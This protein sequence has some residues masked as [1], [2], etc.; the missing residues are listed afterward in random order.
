MKRF[1]ELIFILIGLILIA[2]TVAIL[3]SEYHAT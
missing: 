2:S 1:E 3:F